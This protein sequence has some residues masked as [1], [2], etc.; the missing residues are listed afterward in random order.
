V[1][2]S[3]KL[4]FSFAVTSSLGP[5][6]PSWQLRAFATEIVIRAFCISVGSSKSHRLCP[7]ASLE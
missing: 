3:S 7:P 4:A 1:S 6:N 5:R 2:G